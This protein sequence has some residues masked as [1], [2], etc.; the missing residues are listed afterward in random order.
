MEQGKRREPFRSRISTSA[1]GVTCSTWNKASDASHSEVEI[2]LLFYVSLNCEA[3]FE[4]L[5]CSVAAR[6]RSAKQGACSVGVP[7]VWAL[8]GVA[9]VGADGVS[10]FR[11]NILFHV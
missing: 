1:L 7:R 9:G 3:C 10:I 5:A 11:A 8:R 4:G 6:R 2:L